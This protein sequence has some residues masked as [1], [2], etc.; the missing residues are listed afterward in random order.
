[1][2]SLYLRTTNTLYMSGHRVYE[3]RRLGRADYLEK[4]V[5]LREDAEEI[6]EAFDN[7]ISDVLL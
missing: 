6:A 4:L 7:E 5:L 3:I 2:S 1:M